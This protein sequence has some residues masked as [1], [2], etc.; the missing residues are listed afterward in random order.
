MENRIHSASTRCELR[1]SRCTGNLV[2]FR[3]FLHEAAQFL[4][5]LGVVVDLE[6]EHGVVM[7]PDASILLDDDESGGLHA[8]FIAARRLATLE[9]GHE[10]IS[11]VARRALEAR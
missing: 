4:D 6:A 2:Q 5:R 7:Q 10:T 11:E 3:G 8:A 1:R 9:R